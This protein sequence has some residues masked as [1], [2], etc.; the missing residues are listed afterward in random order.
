MISSKE[1]LKYYISQDGLANQRKTLKIRPL[2]GGEE[3][4]WAFIVHL[5]KL[6]Y[7]SSFKGIKKKIY[8]PIYILK[9]ILLRHLSVKLGFSIPINVTGPG[10]AL[11][12]YGCININ[13]K[14]RIGKNCRIHEGVTIGATNG[15]DKA[16]IIGDNCFIGSGA[17]II[18]DVIIPNDVCIGAGA[19]VVRSIEEAGVTVAGNPA[20]KISDRNSHANLSPLL[21]L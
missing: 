17:K 5:R 8:F 19:V 4:I 21:Q 18:G 6:E 12:H 1:E 7:I 11:P 14:A 20:R 10:L 13:A 9:R 15:S 16:A 3:D 2:I